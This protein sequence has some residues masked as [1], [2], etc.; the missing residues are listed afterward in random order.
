[1]FAANTI[2]K[3]LV[4]AEYSF[5]LIFIS[6]KNIIDALIKANRAL[7][8]IKILEKEPKKTMEEIIIYPKNIP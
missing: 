1:M 6:K 4:N 7:A 5:L 2:W 3:I 8:G